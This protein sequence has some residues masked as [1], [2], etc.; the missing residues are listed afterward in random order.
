MRCKHTFI[1]IKMEKEHTFIRIKL[2][3]YGGTTASKLP[4]VNPKKRSSFRSAQAVGR[5]I[6]ISSSSKQPYFSSQPSA[7]APSTAA[8]ESFSSD[9][10]SF[11]LP[12]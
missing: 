4:S 9:I 5:R 2:H 1:K 12:L 11:V 10:N 7:L 6:S 3:S 8:S